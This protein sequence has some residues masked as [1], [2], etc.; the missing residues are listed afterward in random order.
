MRYFYAIYKPYGFDNSADD[1]LHRFVRP[2]DRDRWVA[3]DTIHR[4]VVYRNHQS[5]RRNVGSPLLRA[6]NFVERDQIWKSHDDHE[7]FVGIASGEH[8]TPLRRPASSDVPVRGDGSVRAYN[9]TAGGESYGV[10]WV[11][12]AHDT[13]VIVDGMTAAVFGGRL[14][15]QG[16][17]AFV[18]ALLADARHDRLID[19]RAWSA[20]HD[21]IRIGNADGFR[22][23]A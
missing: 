9:V 21:S 13:A 5:D 19:R 16:F 14:D 22:L 18:R 8:A 6:F 12:T 4:S 1:E 3:E 7:V 2:I 11:T 15:E 23:V 10:L 17:E 20:F